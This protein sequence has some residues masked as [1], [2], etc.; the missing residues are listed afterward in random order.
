MKTVIEQ[1]E[2]K[3]QS[4]QDGVWLHFKTATGRHAGINMANLKDDGT[5]TGKALTEW[6]REYAIANPPE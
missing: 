3:I 6:A 5:I 1:P 4:V 2:L